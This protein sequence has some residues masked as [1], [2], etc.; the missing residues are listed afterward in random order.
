MIPEELTVGPR[1]LKP[2]CNN[3]AAYLSS[4]ARA[5]W[6]DDCLARV[7]ANEADDVR[8]NADA[9]RRR[10]HTL[11]GLLTEHELT[12]IILLMERMRYGALRPE[13][14]RHFLAIIEG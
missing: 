2:G 4:T 8:R 1:C 14:V 3:P 11:A 6:C 13:S 7:K 12:V 10:I 9:A 5:A